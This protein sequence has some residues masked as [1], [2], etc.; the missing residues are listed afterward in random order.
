M[1]VVHHWYD[2][3]GPRLHAELDDGGH[4]ALTPLALILPGFWRRAVSPALA[5]L[6]AALHAR[7]L[8]VMRIDS[9]GHGQSEGTYT[10]GHEESGDL[11][12]LLARL[13]A[14]GDP[15]AEMWGLS[16]GGTTAV[17]AL[18]D[19]AGE[20]RWPEGLRRL[21]LVSSPVGRPA[22]RLDWFAPATWKQLR[23]SEAVRPP[24]FRL[25]D[26]PKRARV[27]AAAR[28]LGKHLSERACAV[29]AFHC[30]TDWLI[31]APLGRE[32]YA[33]LGPVCKA[34]FIADPRRLH[35]DALLQHY[36][37]EMMAEIDKA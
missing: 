31:E 29:N 34:K 8:R 4:A 13:H 5:P 23:A 33:A 27:E 2:F 9:R 16:M 24:R 30:E 36:L 1:P 14:G 20:N 21:I 28:R 3:G 37:P 7:G 19:L 6:T 12:A 18:D 25:R 17:L 26:F 35:A 15:V 32:L 10:F 22:V 11:A